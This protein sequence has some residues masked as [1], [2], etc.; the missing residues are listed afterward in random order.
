MR[1]IVFLGI[2][3]GAWCSLVGASNPIG[4]A[5]SGGTFRVDDSRVQ[6]NT[7]LFDGTTIETESVISELQLKTGVHVELGAETRATVYQRKLVLDYGQIESAP[8]YDVETH[9]CI[10]SVPRP[11]R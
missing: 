8:A 1:R 6:G 7:T 10:S 4:M 9:S 2:I 11:S 5:F 3:V